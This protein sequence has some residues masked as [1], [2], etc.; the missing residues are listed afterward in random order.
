MRYNPDAPIGTKKGGLKPF[1]VEFIQHD[2]E[3]EYDSSGIFWARTSESADNKARK[4][5]KKW[6]G[7][8]RMHPRRHLDKSVD[9]DAFEEDSPGYRIVELGRTQELKTVGDIINLIC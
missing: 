4:L 3:Y 1:Y 2:G 5:M 9:K 6:W 8:G 7:E